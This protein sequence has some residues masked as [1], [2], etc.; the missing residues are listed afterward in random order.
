MSIIDAVVGVG[1]AHVQSPEHIAVI[2]PPDYHLLHRIY[3]VVLYIV[4]EHHRGPAA[5]AA[6]GAR[7]SGLL[8]S[9]CIREKCR[10]TAKAVGRRLLFS[11]TASSKD[12]QVCSAASTMAQVQP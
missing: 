4:L 3:A 10:P 11:Y 1:T 8:S 7:G 12:C 6:V 2:E 5:G 9:P